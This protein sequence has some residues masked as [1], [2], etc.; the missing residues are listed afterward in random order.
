MLFLPE[1]PYHLLDVSA[2]KRLTL[3]LSSMM[4]AWIRVKQM[5][6]KQVTIVTRNEP[7][8]STSFFHSTYVNY[9]N[10]VLHHRSNDR[11][12]SL[13][14]CISRFFRWQ[15]VKIFFHYLSY[16]SEAIECTSPRRAIGNDL[17]RRRFAQIHAN[18]NKIRR[19]R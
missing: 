17:T 16:L 10:L 12:R 1:G 15:R 9:R 14:V 18:G 4:T 2:P 7:N 13:I 8:M 3:R 11:A 19:N 6:K 5:T